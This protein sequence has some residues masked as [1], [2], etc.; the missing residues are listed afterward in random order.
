MT[1]TEQPIR[2]NQYFSVVAEHA[3]QLPIVNSGD[4]QAYEST[5]EK[6]VV[7]N[8]ETL[9]NITASGSATLSGNTLFSN[10][11]LCTAQTD[12][13]TATVVGNDLTTPVFTA[14]STD[15]AG[16]ISI[17]GVAL[18]GGSILVTYHYTYDNIHTI[19]LTPAN[20]GAAEAMLEGVYVQSN[21]QGFTITI[22]TLSGA[23]PSFNY[24]GIGP[25]PAV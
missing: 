7:N 24:F 5:I 1:S 9:P 15:V 16:R 23:N 8:L 4:L 10:S 25:V 20:A 3:S 13:P 11:N 14:N 12:S 18:T 2:G 19:L 22:E 17:S 6:E 21:N